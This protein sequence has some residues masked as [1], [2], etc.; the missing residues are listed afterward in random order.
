[1]RGYLPGPRATGVCG[2]CTQITK[3]KILTT[4]IYFLDN[5]VYTNKNHVTTF[6]RVSIFKTANYVPK[7]C[8]G[9]DLIHQKFNK[10]KNF[11]VGRSTINHLV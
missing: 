6:L 7:P 9:K 8:T 3:L 1:L 2:M 5:I 11:T 4:L 10:N